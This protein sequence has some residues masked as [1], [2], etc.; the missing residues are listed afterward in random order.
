[1]VRSQN[2]GTDL[3]LWLTPYSWY[4]RWLRFTF[5]NWCFLIEWFTL[6]AG[7]LSWSGSLI[8]P[9]ALALLGSLD[10]P[11]TC[12]CIWFTSWYWCFL[13]PWFTPALLVLSSLL[14]HS[15]SLVLS[16]Q[17]AHYLALVLVINAGS[18]C[19]SG[20]LRGNGSLKSNGTC[21]FIWFT[22]LSWCCDV[23]WF[24]LHC[25]YYQVTWFIQK[26]WYS[27]QR[28]FT[29][30]LWYFLAVWFTRCTWFSHIALV[31]LHR[32]V[33]VVRLGSLLHRGTIKWNGSRSQ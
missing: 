28:W 17:M 22:L 18:L 7:T 13:I 6:F 19:M 31:H 14:V 29:F 4:S 32:L 8:F 3:I 9:D 23:V 25:W 20:T 2:Y 21:L 12:L 26:F 5:S 15:R 16:F 1:M 10:G 30:S 11:G 24:T 27:Q 33:L